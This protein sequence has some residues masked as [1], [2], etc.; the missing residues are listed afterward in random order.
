MGTIFTQHGLIADPYQGYRWI[1]PTDVYLRA[2]KNPRYVE[3][4]V[5]IFVIYFNNNWKFEIIRFKK[6][7]VEM[8]WERRKI[9]QSNQITYKIGS[10]PELLWSWNISYPLMWS[11]QSG[12]GAVFLQD[13]AR[14]LREPCST[15]RIMVVLL[16]DHQ[17]KNGKGAREKTKGKSG[18]VHLKWWEMKMKYKRR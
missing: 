4:F 14:T 5:D 15:E 12:L 16:F 17:N 13:G 6:I 7:S 9:F 18:R 3:L 8:D 10:H 11:S 1:K 2:E